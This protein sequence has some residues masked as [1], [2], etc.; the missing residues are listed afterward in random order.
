MATAAVTNWPVTPP[1]PSA[2]ELANGGLSSGVVS[3]SPTAGIGYGTGAGGTVTQITSKATTVVLNKI[4]GN[5]I[6]HNAS[7]AGAASV[8]FTLTNSTIAA[9]DVVVVG[10]KSG[11]ATGLYTAAVTATAAGS[12]QITITNIGSTAGEVV[13]V[14]FS[15]QKAVAA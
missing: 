14:N 5:V 4:C 7:L 15:V 2:Q 12:C 3:T 1:F 6:S 8:S 13:T 10:V 9:G 11:A